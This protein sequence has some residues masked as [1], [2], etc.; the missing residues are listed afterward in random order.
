MEAG[1]PLESLVIPKESNIMA[2]LKMEP[3]MVW[4]S[5]FG[6]T[7][8][9]T[10]ESGRM[11]NLMEKDVLYIRMVMF[12]MDTGRTVKDMVKENWTVT[13][14]QHTMENGLRTKEKVKEWKKDLTEANILGKFL[15][16]F[17]YFVKGKR[18]GKGKLELEND[19]IY[20][21]NFENDDFIDGMGKLNL[22]DG[23]IYEGQ[24]K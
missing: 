6:L 22:S 21:G 17:S 24:I 5:R 13:T 7:F 11:T 14:R 4:E 12:T 20:D 8:L 10:R 3:K 23:R 9:F 2:I 1:R 18:Q 15:L 19:N 16:I